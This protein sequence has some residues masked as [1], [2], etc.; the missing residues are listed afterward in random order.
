MAL[1]IDMVR[2]VTKST[3][4]EVPDLDVLNF[5]NL[6][7]DFTVASI[8]KVLLPFLSTSINVQDGNGTPIEN[9]DMVI[10]VKRNGRRC[11]IISPVQGQD[12]NDNESLNRVTA[13]YPK[14]WIEGNLIYIA[15]PPTQNESAFIYAIQ[16]PTID[17][18]T[19]SNDV[20]Y[21]NI[22]HIIIDFA[23]ALDFT[24]L[25]A[26]YSKV[27]LDDWQVGGAGRDALDKARDIIDDAAAASNPDQLT[28]SAIGWISYEDS[29]MA[30]SAISAAAQEVNRAMAEIQKMQPL[31]AETQGYLNKAQTYFDKAF[32][33]I[34]LYIQ[35]SPIYQQNTQQ[36]GA[37]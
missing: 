14:F 20:P 10:D 34:A 7:A 22:L 21:N 24:A 2:S 15:P 26:Y 29:E 9:V 19:D 12:A 5:L 6:A 4:T 28:L 11:D 1:L 27:N 37:K 31:T 8:P 36:Q 35:A 30:Q 17:E 13:F 33:E 18:N 32:K 25:G 23:I 16:P 3:D